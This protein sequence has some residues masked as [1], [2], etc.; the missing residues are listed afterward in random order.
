MT[1]VITKYKLVIISAIYF[2][3]YGMVMNTLVMNH[4]SIRRM[5]GQALENRFAVG[6]FMMNPYYTIVHQN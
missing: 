5:G 2:L 1:K 4:D 6:R 3:S